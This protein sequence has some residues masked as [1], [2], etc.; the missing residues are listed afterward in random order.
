MEMEGEKDLET[1]IMMEEEGLSEEGEI[2]ASAERQDRY[3]FDHRGCHP[4]VGTIM[5]TLVQS[6]ELSYFLQVTEDEERVKDAVGTLFGGD[7]VTQR[8]ELEGHYGNKIVWIR[9]HLVG[10]QAA[11]VLRELV[12]HLDEDETKMILAELGQAMDEHN[13]LYIRLSKQV[14]V[15]Q[16]R[17]VLASSD[18]IRV[19]VKPRSYLVG[20]TRSRSMRSYF[21]TRGTRESV[22]RP[23]AQEIPHAHKRA[24]HRRGGEEGVDAQ[25]REISPVLAKK[26]VWFEHALIVKT[27]NVDVPLVRKPMELSAGGVTLESKLTSGFDR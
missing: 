15:M 21:C 10:E 6:L 17:L 1:M 14:L 3:R 9:H 25:D 2:V 22:E 18:P 19:K 27:D 16:G 20:A 24:D 23:P 12:S 5:A 13:A 11:S 7:L 4:L 26:A 8:Q